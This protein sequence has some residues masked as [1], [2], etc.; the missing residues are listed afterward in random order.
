MDVEKQPLATH[1]DGY[2]LDDVG[3]SHAPSQTT[4]QQPSRSWRD[5][6]A[7]DVEDRST[8]MR[9]I[10][11]RKVDGTKL[12]ETAWLDGL[13]GAAASLVTLYHMNIIIF[14]LYTETPYGALETQK[15]E[16]WRLPFI[17]ILFASGHTQVCIFFVLSGFVLSWGTLKHI[18]ARNNDR[19]LSSLGSAF[20]RRWFRLYLPC[21]AWSFIMFVAWQLGMA[22]IPTDH[23]DNIF[24]QFV[25]LIRTCAS[26]SDPFKLNRDNWSSL[27][28]YA[29]HMWTIPYEFLG[30][31]VVFAVLLA[32]HRVPRYKARVIVLGV[33]CFVAF[34]ASRW[35]IWLFIC[36]VMIADYVQ[37][38]GGFSGIQANETAK[39]RTIWHVV[40][41]F[42]LYLMS[43]PEQNEGWTRPGYDWLKRFVPANWIHL[44][45]G[46]RLWWSISGLM[47]IICF[48]HLSWARQFF[49]RSTM[50]YLGRISFMLYLSHR[51]VLEVFGM[52]LRQWFFLNL[53]H[54]YYDEV[55]K[56]ELHTAS[57]TLNT[58][59]YVLTVLA[60]LPP[61]GP[62][63][64]L[65]EW[66]IDKPSVR[67]AKWLDSFL[68]RD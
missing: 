20:L 23:K 3:P 9:I 6:L 19:V 36:G 4:A 40:L 25:E 8:I 17:R 22:D 47:T 54:K 56:I 52:P 66:S 48:C 58:V 29:W 35:G 7:D 64:N 37:Q 10:G 18:R 32:A 44:E 13:R 43:V 57:A 21:F 14:G 33:P 31:V 30:S 67:F 59:F 16:L 27:N 28:P 34:L 41:F 24:S 62:I 39:T 60:V 2:A 26:W 65:L 45:G 50:Q 1:V 55:F 5:L 38:M 15:W 51:F 68:T 12:S 53:G 42:A 46:D 11:W 63:A 61:M 49:E